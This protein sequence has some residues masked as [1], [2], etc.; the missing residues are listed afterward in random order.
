MW[1][2]QFKKEYY[3]EYFEVTEPMYVKPREFKILNRLG[4]AYYTVKET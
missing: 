3:K 4:K 2:V 1:D